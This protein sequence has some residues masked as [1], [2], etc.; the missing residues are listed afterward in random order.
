MYPDLKGKY[1]IVTG[2]AS[3]QGIGRAIVEALAQ[4]GVNVCCTDIATATPDF[5]MEAMGYTYGGN[6]ALEKTVAAAKA[7]GVNAIA[8]TADVTKADEVEEMVKQAHAQLGRIDILVNVAGG[9]WGSNRVAEY[10]PEQWLKTLHI[11]LF[12]TFLT[13]KFCLSYMENQGSGA[14]VNIASIAAERSH[15]MVSA[16]GAAKAGVVQFTRDVATEYGPA[17]IRA[18]AILPGDIKT[19]MLAMEFRGMAALLDMSEDDVAELS[20][21]GTPLRR[22]GQPKDVADTAV[23][24]ASDAASFLTGLSIPVTGGKHLPFRAH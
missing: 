7:Y 1:A 9:S 2:C 19:E 17:G 13:T 10:D 12:G 6:E 5:L 15:D 16:Y 18:N 23:F 14:I 22:L 4:E 11:N 20:S 8:L 3:E 24:L 21:Q